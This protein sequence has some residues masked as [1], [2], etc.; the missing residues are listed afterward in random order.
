MTF[1]T[2]A[3]VIS[4]LMMASVTL[5]T[6]FSSAKMVRNMKKEDYQK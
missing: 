6:V 1:A 3:R 4:R 2:A 5:M